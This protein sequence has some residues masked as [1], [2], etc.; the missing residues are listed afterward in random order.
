M[1]LEHIDR[2]EVWGLLGAGQ[3]VWF[4]RFYS[5]YDSNL[6]CLN[7]MK[8]TDV[9]N[10][11]W[12]ENGVFF[13]KVR[14]DSEGP[15]PSDPRHIYSD[16]VSVR[17]IKNSDVWECINSGC[18]VFALNPNNIHITNLNSAT[19]GEIRNIIDN[20]S[21]MFFEQVLLTAETVGGE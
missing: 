10:M 20:E 8:L 6:E 15:T 16:T 14:D 11:L 3:S 7:I 4:G 17:P 12:Y 2:S 19:I 5:G 18:T 9:L 21:L 1:K 13:K